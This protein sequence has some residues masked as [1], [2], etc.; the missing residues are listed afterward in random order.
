MLVHLRHALEENKL[1]LKSDKK[2]KTIEHIN[3]IFDKKTIHPEIESVEKFRKRIQKIKKKVENAGLAKQLD[4]IKNQIAL[5]A[6]KLEHL[7]HDNDRRNKDYLGNLGT[8]KKERE[9]FQKNIEDILKEQ[10]KINIKFSF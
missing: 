6:L 1:N 8:L 7:E 5:N 3:A 2:D 9:D 4:D 10:I